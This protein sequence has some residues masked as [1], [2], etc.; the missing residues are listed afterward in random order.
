MLLVNPQIA[1]GN[2]Q[3]V[4]VLILIAG[5]FAAQLLLKFD[6]A[7]LVG[8][9]NTK[10]DAGYYQIHIAIARFPNQFLASKRV[11]QFAID[12][13]HLLSDKLQKVGGGLFANTLDYK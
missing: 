6:S 11:H 1:D 2:A 9:T 4:V 3:V 12:S 5:E 7:F 8:C 10:P 13:Y